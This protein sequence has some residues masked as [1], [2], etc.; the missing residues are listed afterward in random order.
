MDN[1]I[2]P[3]PERARNQTP[4]G[5]GQLPEQILRNTDHIG[6]DKSSDC[7]RASPGGRENFE[8]G[9][10]IFRVSGREFAQDG[11][12]QTPLDPLGQRRVERL[13]RT[14]YSFLNGFG[15]WII[16]GRKIS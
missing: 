5:I 9:P 11:W 10:T 15:I 12:T 4:R 7:S 6:D 14:I 16:E 1:R 3:L 8:L 2:L 13:L